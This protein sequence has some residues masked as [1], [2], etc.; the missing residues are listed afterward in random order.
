MCAP[1]HVAAM[2][3]EVR[4]EIEQKKAFM[5]GLDNEGHPIVLV[6]VRNHK[7]ASD[8]EVRVGWGWGGAGWGRG[9]HRPASDVELKVG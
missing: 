6:V 9:G 3:A 2:Q 8:I 1:M 7:P 5:Q 4:V